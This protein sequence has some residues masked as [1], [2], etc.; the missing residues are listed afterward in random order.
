[1]SKINNLS[2]FKF[3][4][5]L[6]MMFNVILGIT[7]IKLEKKVLMLNSRLNM[8]SNNK[9]DVINLNSINL[10]TF[11]F[12]KYSVVC[13]DS[14]M[15]DE[16]EIIANNPINEDVVFII[17]SINN[18]NVNEDKY[19]YIDFEEL[20][21]LPMFKKISKVNEIRNKLKT[22]KSLKKFKFF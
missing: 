2:V 12:T 8:N 18:T 1:M 19:T 10:K 7:K 22:N 3:G 11:D 17:C 9:I 15:S 16:L 14:N 21:V 20:S 4:I 13:I 5:N 6:N